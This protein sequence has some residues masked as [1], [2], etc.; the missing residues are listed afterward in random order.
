MN[1]PK[2]PCPKECENRNAECHT[3]CEKW[4]KY[5][6]EHRAYFE[7]VNKRNEIA[8]YVASIFY[9]SIHDRKAGKRHRRK[10]T[11]K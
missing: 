8:Y 2:Q 3:K 10:P 9:D 1:R 5:E 4:L 6:K 11:I 7:E